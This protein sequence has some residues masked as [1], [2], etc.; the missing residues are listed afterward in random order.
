MKKQKK[1]LIGQKFGRWSV[2]VYLMER[3]TENGC[4]VVSA[5]RN[6]MFWNAV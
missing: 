3:L 4:A 6:A 2:R 5:E 1:D